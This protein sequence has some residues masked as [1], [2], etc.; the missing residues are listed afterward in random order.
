[1]LKKLL[2]LIAGAG[3]AQLITV[4]ALPILARVYG[5]D[6]FG[7][8]GTL[9]AIVSLAAV[10]GHGRY[11][12]AIPGA[13]NREEAVSLLVLSNFLAAL[14]ALPLVLIFG[15]AG[16]TI[17]REGDP[18]FYL[19]VASVLTWLT[20]VID[21]FNYWR[22]YDGRFLV[23]ARNGLVRSGSTVVGQFLFLALPQ[24]GLIFGA[25]AG[26]L[27]AAFVAVLDFFK[28]R[29][30]LDA[31]AWGVESLVKVARKY[32]SFPLYGVPQGWLASLSWNGM[33]IL[34]ARFGG[35][36]FAGQYWV[37]YR[38]IITPVALL[39]GAYRQAVLP[40]L[41]GGGEAAVRLVL[42]HTI[43]IAC[44]LVFP[45][46]L[47]FVY[48]SQ[49]FRA[50]IGSEWAEAGEIM[51]W[52]AIAVSG[53]LIKIPVQCLM[54]SMHKQKMALQWEWWIIL[55]RYCVVVPI[56]VFGSSMLAVAVFGFLGLAGW[57]IFTV[58]QFRN[59][60]AGL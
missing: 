52:M 57:L 31:I 38:L 53:D 41:R 16:S 30:S 26:V 17:V 8:L 5:P 55:V 59:F 27:A 13:G 35:L 2:V 47:I 56:L 20:C 12:M 48:G 9:M 46:F 44:C 36:D 34:L 50:A 22:S 4:V 21:I 49:V 10:V 7:E 29:R 3:A 45:V 60:K 42:K 32:K 1:M 33:P 24:Y 25:L 18:I 39:N 19:V 11:H 51:S 40:S 6:E 43:A 14:L 15:S 58:L 37:A 23:T 54:Q 28:N